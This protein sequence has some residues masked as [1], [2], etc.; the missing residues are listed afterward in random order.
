MFLRMLVEVCQAFRRLAQKQQQ[1]R[2]NNMSSHATTS[3]AS[4]GSRLDLSRWRSVPIVLIILGALGVLGAFIFGDVA[5]KRQVAYSYLVAYIYFLSIC[6][7]CWFLVLIH[8]LFDAM[9]SVPL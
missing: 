6:A 5:L 7:G 4:A 8:H 3:D 2:R 9:W 1:S